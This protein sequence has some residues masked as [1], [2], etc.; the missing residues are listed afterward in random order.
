MAKKKAIVARKSATPRKAVTPRKAATPQKAATRRKSSAPLPDSLSI[1]MYC[2]GTGD[3]FVLRYYDEQLRPFTV[4]IDCGSCRGDRAAF[5]PYLRDLA[6]Y[7]GNKVDLLVV[8]HEHNDHVNGFD[9]WQDLFE[10]FA[11]GEA[12]FAWT[13]NPDDPEGQAQELL[14]KRGKMRSALSAAITEIRKR[15]AAMP[16]ALTDNFY[17]DQM[18]AANA[19]FIS[20]L[21]TLADINLDAAG[22][23]G[24]GNS[25][26]TSLAGMTRIK[27]ILQK[28]KVRIKYLAPGET[29]SLP[30]LSGFKFHVLGPPM[31]RGQVFKDGKEGTDVYRRSFALNESSLA[32]NA[33]NS[34]FSGEDD[35]P[36]HTDFVVRTNVGPGNA[37]KGPGN[38]EANEG[39]IMENYSAKANAWR[40]IDDDWLGSAG[41]LALRLNSHINNTSLALAIESPGGKVI[42]MPGDA[43]F[44]SWESWHLIK[45]WDKQGRGGKHLVEDLLNRVVF[46]KVSHHLSYNGTALEKGID[47]LLSEELVS[48]ATLDRTRISE[49]WK[50]TMPNKF[51]IQELIRRT[52][53][54]LFIMNEDGIENAPSQSF[55]PATLGPEVYEEGISDDGMVLYKQYVLKLS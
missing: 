43:E 17:K 20:G 2:L 3:C 37:R 5:E 4:M 22:A 21:D 18:M 33:F 46:Y 52:Q 25:G 10:D 16:G 27:E 31:D 53:G 19:A 55:D 14:K 48:M 1:R 36:F 49:K 45:K 6:G 40:T 13:E 41:S 26:R 47:M 42:L 44:G 15:N 35:L 30:G 12:W 54:K 29:I 51:L 32:E 38:A 11:I 7:V 39:A 23:A 8:T 34:W 24:T 50:S 9:K 28:K